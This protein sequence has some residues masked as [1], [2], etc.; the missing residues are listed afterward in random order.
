MLT[1]DG[2]QDI[3]ILNDRF[4]EDAITQLISIEAHNH[5]ISGR[6]LDPKSDKEIL[7]SITNDWD[8][9]QHSIKAIFDHPRFEEAFSQLTTN[10]KFVSSNI[11]W[12]FAKWQ[13]ILST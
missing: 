11:S 8:L 2:L 1:E 5:F 3:Y 12:V 10:S 9:Y 13:G 4:P 7:S 6:F